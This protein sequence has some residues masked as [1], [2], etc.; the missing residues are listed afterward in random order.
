VIVLTSLFVHFWNK[1]LSVLLLIIS[2]YCLFTPKS[3]RLKMPVMTTPKT[4]SRSF[5]FSNFATNRTWWVERSVCQWFKKK[6]L[7]V[8][9]Y[10]SFLLHN[11]VFI[12][13]E[14]H[15]HY[16]FIRRSQMDIFPLFYYQ[17]MDLIPGGSV[18]LTKYYF[19]GLLSGWKDLFYLLYMLDYNDLSHGIDMKY[20]IFVS[21]DILCKL[22]GFLLDCHHKLV[23]SSV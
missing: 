1:R 13:I 12:I 4:R 6:Y 5:R 21:E 7:I 14:L 15:W 9:K 10:S 17:Y 3:V 8:L 2:G 11:F 18:R 23:C 20:F 19:Y 22:Y 16:I